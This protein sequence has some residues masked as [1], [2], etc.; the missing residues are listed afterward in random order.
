MV[1]RC[2]VTRVARGGWRDTKTRGGDRPTGSGSGS[3]PIGKCVVG[4]VLV[5]VDACQCYATAIVQPAQLV[6][7]IMWRR[8]RYA[9]AV[10]AKLIMLLARAMQP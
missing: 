1:Q 5:L 3:N 2:A 10:V 9:A 6:A 4:V 8:P 7:L